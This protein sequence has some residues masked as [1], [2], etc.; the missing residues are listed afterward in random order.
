MQT[1]DRKQILFKKSFF[2]DSNPGQ[3]DDFREMRLFSLSIYKRKISN[4]TTEIV[5]D[6]SHFDY[7]RE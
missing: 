3:I 2:G 7:D 6:T 1:S 4:L 5:L